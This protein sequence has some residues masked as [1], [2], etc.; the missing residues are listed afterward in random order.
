MEQN[1]QISERSNGSSVQNRPSHKLSCCWTKIGS[2]PCFLL[3]SFHDILF[4][5]SIYYL[6]LKRGWWFWGGEN[7]V[8]EREQERDVGESEGRDEKKMRDKRMGRIFISLI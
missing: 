8:E 6:F 7:Q 1:L 4:F 5:L 2:T 3:L